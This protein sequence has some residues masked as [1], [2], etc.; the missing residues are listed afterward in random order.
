VIYITTRLHGD[1]SPRAVNPP[2]RRVAIALGQVFCA[3][4]ASH[5]GTDE[6]PFPFAAIDLLASDLCEK[7]KWRLAGRDAISDPPE[8][9]GVSESTPEHADRVAIPGQKSKRGAIH[10]RIAP[11]PAHAAAQFAADDMRD[12][13]RTDLF[14]RIAP[15]T[16]R[17]GSCCD[18]PKQLALTRVAIPIS[19]EDFVEEMLSSHLIQR[20][21]APFLTFG[22]RA[23]GSYRAPALA[24]LGDAMCSRT[25]FSRAKKGAICA[26]ASSKA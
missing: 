21:Q 7:W 24:I 12:S 25:C 11:L 2:T 23:G 1:L 18:E 16:A 6:A 8:F 17:T 10:P 22:C 26:H 20:Q 13:G 3:K 5:A 9:L 4:G 15:A 19:G 14:P